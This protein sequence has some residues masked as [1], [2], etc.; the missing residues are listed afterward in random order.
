[1]LDPQIFTTYLPLTLLDVFET[2]Q[3]NKIMIYG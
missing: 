3:L 2:I 1:M